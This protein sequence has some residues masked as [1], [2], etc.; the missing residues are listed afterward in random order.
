M[1]LKVGIVGYGVVGKNRHKALDKHPDFSVAAIS[2]IAFKD[3]PIH[4]DGIESF[5]DYKD[6]IKS[7]LVDVLFISLPNKLINDNIDPTE[8]KEAIIKIIKN[9]K[10]KEWK[11]ILA[12]EQNICC[13]I[14]NSLEEAMQDSQII[15]RELLS[16]KMKIGNT[17][18]SPMPTPIAPTWRP[19]EILKNAPELGEANSFYM[20][21]L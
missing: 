18:I 1:S 8:T 15:E 16:A 12:N 3:S 2:D 10:T 21:K 19:K 17:E 4:L 9:K 14:V 13:S 7:N 6:L 5:I 11:D 20:E